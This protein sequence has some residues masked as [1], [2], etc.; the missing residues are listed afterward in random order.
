MANNDHTLH[1]RLIVKPLKSMA[2]KKMITRFKG[3]LIINFALS[4]ERD[5]G[6]TLTLKDNFFEF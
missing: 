5:N 1:K 2:K 3:K 6:N 4:E